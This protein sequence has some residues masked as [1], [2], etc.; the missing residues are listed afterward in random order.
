MEA[1][2]ASSETGIEFDREQAKARLEKVYREFEAIQRQ[3]LK[4]SVEIFA[5]DTMEEEHFV[6]RYFAVKTI[7]KRFIKQ[8]SKENCIAEY[9]CDPKLLQ[10][11]TDTAVTMRCSGRCF[12]RHDTVERKRGISDYFCPANGYSRS[13]GECHR[14]S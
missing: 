13:R 9:G 12:G 10:L 1:I 5:E 7:L 11:Q 4:K 2:E 14:I 3:L 6:E 8:M